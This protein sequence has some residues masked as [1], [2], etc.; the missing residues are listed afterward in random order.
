MPEW[1]ALG[2]DLLRVAAAYALAL[3]LAF[4]RE[5]ETRNGGLR[6]FP[7]VAIAACG[8]VLMAARVFTDDAQAQARIVQGVITG[9]GFI[10][11]GAILKE[12]GTVRGTVTAASIWTTGAIG[13]SVAYGRYE[14]A[15]VLAVVNFVTLRWLTPVKQVVDDRRGT[16]E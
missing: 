9:I 4:D 15:I 2:T 8:F 11:G 1:S 7:V 3:P 14:L 13:A 10:G 5:Q 16:P 6:T 12:G